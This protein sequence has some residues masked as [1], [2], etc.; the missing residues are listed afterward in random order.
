MFTCY[1]TFVDVLVDNQNDDSHVGE[2]SRFTFFTAMAD[3]A[4]R[5]GQYLDIFM[6]R[7]Q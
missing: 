1:D 7:P 5:H 3:M 2:S 6:T 4:D